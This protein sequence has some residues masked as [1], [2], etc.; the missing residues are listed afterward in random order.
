MEAVALYENLSQIESDKEGYDM[1]KVEKINKYFNR[2][3][4]NEIHAINNTTLTF[5]DTGLVCILGESGSGKTT[6]LNVIGGLESFDGGNITVDE[7]QIEKYSSAKMD[8]LRNR[9]YGYIFQNYYLLSEYTVEYNIRIALKCFHMTEA[10]IEERVN[11]VLDSV[12][13]RRYKKRLVSELSGGQRQR[14]AIARALAKTPDVI[15]ADEPTGNLDENNTLRIMSILRK[16][17]KDC[18]VILVTHEQRIAE[19]FADRIIKVKDGSVV[20]D[21]INKKSSSYVN[22]ND[23]N[24]YLKEY[25]KKELTVGDSHFNIYSDGLIQPININIVFRDG[26]VYIDADGPSSIEYIT[27]ESETAFV[28]DVKPQIN[29]DDID[30]FEFTLEK[31]QPNGTNKLSFAEVFSMAI[32]NIRSTGK[33]QMFMY[34]VFAMSSILMLLSISDFYRVST[35]KPYEVAQTDSHY[36]LVECEETRIAK[37]AYSDFCESSG[38]DAKIYGS[39]LK[40]LTITNHNYA[41]IKNVKQSLKD[42]SYV[43]IKYL[44][45]EQLLY[46]RMPE[47]E[48]EIV[49]DKAVLDGV[50]NGD[51][52]LATLSTDIKD[53]LNVPATNKGGANQ[54]YICGISDNHEMSIYIDESYIS[55]QGQSDED[56]YNMRKFLL[57]T[58]EPEAVASY[59]TELNKQYKAQYGDEYVNMEPVVKATYQYG[60]AI[61]AYKKDMQEDIGL[62]T[63]ITGIV[64]TLAMVVLFFTMKANSIRRTEELVVYRLIGIT[65]ANIMMSY[66]IEICIITAYT[67]II[68]MAVA[69]AVCKYLSGVIDI[70]ILSL[71]P[72]NYM[73]A[74]VVGIFVANIL[75]SLLSVIGIIK[76]PPARL[77]A[78]N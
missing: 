53:Y 17:S 32:Y 40:G 65:P 61:D 63:I 43:D 55:W 10:E 60:Q 15:F 74:L 34:V 56:Y 57:Y 47:S 20:E 38:I 28:D 18:L 12:G 29:M 26:K 72:W 2:N 44:D 16:I 76:R 46:G 41:Q 67:Q 14:V 50:I 62:R 35:I 36:V 75:V 19:F 64:V 48:N 66:V 3:K 54:L 30:Q 9:K 7:D 5:E 24:I 71:C 22:K 68:P 45:E 27:D 52:V 31:V 1:I 21:S 59:F 23:T 77:A 73:L 42:F 39:T 58:E 25:E 4:R 37:K 78:K 69:V 11:Y 49:V 33:K 8:K 13:M 70:D 6:L 51:T